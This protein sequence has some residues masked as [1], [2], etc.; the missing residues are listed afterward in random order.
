MDIE[1]AQTLWLKC[2][3][4]IT[5]QFLYPLFFGCYNQRSIK[6]LIIISRDEYKLGCLYKARSKIK[7]K[8]L[9]LHQDCVEEIRLD[10]LVIENVEQKKE[11]MAHYAQLELNLQKEKKL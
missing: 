3:P 11:A 2:S 5:I 6:A 9:K 7:Q 10:Y 4:T 1:F 8:T